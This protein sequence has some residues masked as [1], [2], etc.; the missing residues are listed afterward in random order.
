MCRRVRETFLILLV[1]MCGSVNRE[2]QQVTRTCHSLLSL[3]PS[4]ASSLTH[5]LTHSSTHLHVLTHSPPHP[6]THSPLGTNTSRDLA[7]VMFKWS[8][9]LSSELECCSPSLPSLSPSHAAGRGTTWG[10]RCRVPD[11]SDQLDQL[12]QP[13]LPDLPELQTSQT[14]QTS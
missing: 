4:L 7:W 5:P 13:E 11:L 10:E 14:S 3:H 12:D 9:W 6:L 8:S 2:A 1:S